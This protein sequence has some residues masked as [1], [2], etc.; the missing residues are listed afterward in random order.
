MGFFTEKQ[1]K[2]TCN[3]CGQVWYYTKKDL[4]VAKQNNRLNQAKKDFGAGSFLL[5]GGLL[6][7]AI[8]ASPELPTFSAYQ[9]PR[10]GSRNVIREFDRRILK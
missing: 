6:S 5:G 4:F 7:M 1:Y 2:S 3:S 10:C 8:M 9:C